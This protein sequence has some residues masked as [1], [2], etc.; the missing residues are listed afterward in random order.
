MHMSQPCSCPLLG[1]LIDD[2]DVAWWPVL[3]IA[4]CVVAII[5]TIVTV[6]MVVVGHR[7]LCVDSLTSSLSPLASACMLARGFATCP[8][9]QLGGDGP[10]FLFQ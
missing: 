2:S 3:L 5:L 8:L 9:D 1:G 4:G 6:I 7:Q 10:P